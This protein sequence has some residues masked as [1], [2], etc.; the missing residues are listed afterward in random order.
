MVGV[1]RAAGSLHCCSAVVLTGAPYFLTGL[2][3]RF[4][5]VNVT[6]LTLENKVGAFSVAGWSL[7]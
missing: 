4:L 3:T 7:R 1:P 2:Q 5:P 6:E